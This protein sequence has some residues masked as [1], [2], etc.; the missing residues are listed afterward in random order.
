MVRTL[1]LL[2][3]AALGLWA[4]AKRTSAF[5]TLPFAALAGVLTAAGTCAVHVAV[6]LGADSSL[7]PAFQA[8]IAASSLFILLWGER[9]CLLDGRRALQCV[10]VASL[11]SFAVVIG[12]SVFPSQIQIAVHVALPLASGAALVCLGRGASRTY[13]GNVREGLK[14]FPVRAFVGIGLFGAM[15]L[16]LQSFSEGKT[17]QPDEILW[18]VAGVIVNAGVLLVSIASKREIRASTLSK[19]ILPLFVVSVFFVFATDFGQQSIEVFAIGCAWI[20][21][22]LFT[23]VIWRV[24]ALRTALPP[25]SVLAVGQLFLTAGTM[26]GSLA[27]GALVASGA[28]QLVA[29]AFICI[30]GILVAMFFLDTHYVARL[31]DGSTAFDPENRA[32]CE[33][34]V[35][36]ATERYGLSRQERAIA[37]MLVRGD[38]NEA[39]KDELVIATNTLRTHLRN[40]YK[41]TGSHS[42]EELVLLLRSLADA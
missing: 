6:A 37:L 42:R 21:L 33:R 10:V 23:W 5:S 3:L 27:H 28:S 1:W 25:M 39:I 15:V 30:L 36:R 40:L 4:L 2:A 22:R 26:A 31:A 13:D 11:V 16:L 29:M 20:Y 17:E 12:A 7:L 38:D 18:I 8:P 14:R 32:V 34:C 41:K 35:D 24:G 19:L 9:L